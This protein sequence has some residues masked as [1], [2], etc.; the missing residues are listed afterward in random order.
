[1]SK[2]VLTFHLSYYGMNLPSLQRVG[3]IYSEKLT[4]R[5]SVGKY[6]GKKRNRSSLVTSLQEE[7]PLRGVNCYRPRTV[8]GAITGRIWII[9]WQKA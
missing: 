7:L 2:G 8:W 9:V 4:I 1:M 6:R 5:G 3:K